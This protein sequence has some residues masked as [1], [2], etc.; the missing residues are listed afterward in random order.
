[1]FDLPKILNYP[2]QRRIYPFLGVD[3]DEIK[4]LEEL[5]K[6][7]TRKGE[8]FK[9]EFLNLEDFI[10]DYRLAPYQKEEYLSFHMDR[11]NDYH[12]S[13]GEIVKEML[14]LHPMSESKKGMNIEA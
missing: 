7:K 12:D 10:D 4:K 13:Q 3:H 9:S 5:A 14:R 6:E 11:F 2:N 1:M 8:T